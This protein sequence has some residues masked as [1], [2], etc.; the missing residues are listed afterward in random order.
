MHI[1]KNSMSLSLLSNLHT[2]SMLRLFT[3]SICQVLW[4]H[5]IS[6]EIL[7]KKCFKLLL[8]LFKSHLYI[9]NIFGKLLLSFSKFLKFCFWTY[10]LLMVLFQYMRCGEGFIICYSITDRHS[11]VEAEEYRNLIQ[12]VRQ[13]TMLKL[14]YVRLGLQ[15]TNN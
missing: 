9:S 15:K 8:T 13:E 14:G 3:K 6:Y 4:N 10:S 1:G 2:K 11:F 5:L 12:K 7:Q